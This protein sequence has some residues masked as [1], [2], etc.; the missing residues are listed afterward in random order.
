MRRVSKAARQDSFFDGMV[1]RMLRRCGAQV[2]RSP[3]VE[4]DPFDG[5]AR[6]QEGP[7]DENSH[8]G[9]GDR[10]HAQALA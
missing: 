6:E 9:E 10:G 4:L 3:L 8:D 1:A 5:V 2:R 7:E